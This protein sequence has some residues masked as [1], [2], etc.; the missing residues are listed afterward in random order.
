M[1]EQVFFEQFGE[2]EG[3]EILEGH[4]PNIV[5]VEIDT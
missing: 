1:G 3:M 2:A 5:A 4:S